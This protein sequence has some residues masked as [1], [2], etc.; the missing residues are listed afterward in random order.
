[1]AFE[2]HAGKRTAMIANH[3]GEMLQIGLPENGKF[4]TCTIL[5]QTAMNHLITRP[6]DLATIEKKKVDS[7]ITL[8]AFS[9]AIVQ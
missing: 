5:D 6:Q 8:P 2:D 7:E 1:M 3:T 9:I 4:S